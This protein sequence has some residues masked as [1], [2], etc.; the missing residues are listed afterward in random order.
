M[1][2]FVAYQDVQ[3]V[4]PMSGQYGA[5]PRG[6]YYAF[7]LFVII[8][9]RQDWLTAAAAASAFTFGAS[10]VLHSVVLGID[11]FDSRMGT[12][13]SS[14][15]LSNGTLV[16]VFAKATDLD[17]HAT[18]SIAGTGLIIAGPLGIWQA[19]VK[20]PYSEPILMIWSIMI[21]AGIFS[22]ASNL[23]NEARAEPQF[24]FCSLGYNVTLPVNNDMIDVVGDS[25]N[26][27]IWTYFGTL[28]T[29]QSG[30][31]YPCLEVINAV[32][33][34]GDATALVFS[35]RRWPIWMAVAITIGGFAY[36][37]LTLLIYT[38]VHMKLKQSAINFAQRIAKVYSNILIYGVFPIYVLCMEWIV[39]YDLQSESIQMIGQW[40]PLV[41]TA[42]VFIAAAIGRFWPPIKRFMKS[43]LDR[44]YLVWTT[45]LE[46]SPSQSYNSVRNYD[47]S[48]AWYELGSVNFRLEEESWSERMKRK[49]QRYTQCAVQTQWNMLT[50]RRSSGRSS[51]KSTNV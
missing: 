20:T 27:T 21:V 36:L 45:N 39:H 31:Y 4:F 15:L 14:V 43:Y 42:L 24:R 30:C 32:R 6:L 22:G 51:T 49:F 25:W 34:H 46:E 5:A 17:S 38:G 50:P 48:T 33:Q 7:L 35:S 9:K 28:N 16:K 10:T 11:S 23:W 26:S 19:R 18:L 12:A 40:A 44:R 13:N 41:G 3:C 37:L 47:T 2:D 29:S 8:F 1:V